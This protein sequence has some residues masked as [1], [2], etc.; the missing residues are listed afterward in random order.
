MFAAG[1]GGREPRGQAVGLGFESERPAFRQ[2][3]GLGRLQRAQVGLPAVDGH[4]PV[5]D[6]TG[7]VGEFEAIHA[8][9]ARVVESRLDRRTVGCH[10]G[11]RGFAVRCLQGKSV[12]TRARGRLEREDQRL[13][14]PDDGGS[15]AIAGQVED[16]FVCPG[17]EVGVGGQGARLGV[18]RA[19]RAT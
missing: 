1:L 13:T 17:D 7:R 4:C 18:E 11:P 14:R 15:S 6:S 9:L 10:D 3:G 2:L 16:P 5:N 19:L 12:D 8:G